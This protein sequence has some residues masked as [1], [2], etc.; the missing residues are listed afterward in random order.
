MQDSEETIQSAEKNYTSYES[1]GSFH[2]KKQKTIQNG[3]LKKTLFSSSANSQY[4]FT[5]ISWIASL[6]IIID[7]CEGHWCGLTC[8]VVGLSNVSSKTGKKCIFC[9]FRL[10]L[11]FCRT[12]LRPYKLRNINALRINQFY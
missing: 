1:Q 6:V 4:F 12:A 2:W 9:V 8:M 7:L 10:F 11:S 5:K 3:R